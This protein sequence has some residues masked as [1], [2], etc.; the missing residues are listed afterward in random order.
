ML[1]QKFKYVIT[2]YNNYTSHAWTMP[3]CSKAAAIMAAKDFLEMVCVQHD[4]HVVRWMSDAGREYKS[5]LFD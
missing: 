3:L 4:A 2:F 5:D 1:Y